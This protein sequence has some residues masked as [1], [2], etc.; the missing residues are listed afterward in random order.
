MSILRHAADASSV[1]MFLGA[2]IVINEAS[3]G[4]RISHPAPRLITVTE[5]QE[6]DVVRTM[7]NVE[8]RRYAPC[9]MADV[10]VRGDYRRATYEGFGP[11]VTY[12][13]RNDIAMTAPVV[14]EDTGNESWRV[15]FVMP[16]GMH[17]ST[18]P[19]PANQQVTLRDVPE[20]LAAALKFAGL[21][22]RRDVARK[23][24]DLLAA[25]RIEGLTPTS[26]VRVARFDPPWT[27]SF[28]R[29]N[30]LVVDVAV[31]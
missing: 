4:T 18:L 21:A 26:A 27:P 30:E 23:E 13:S 2:P 12:I 15:S 20:H 6:Y 11:L 17:L 19:R 28:L 29:H 22:T 5:Q 25:L 14:Q 8:L 1:R 16:S 3:A 7:G 10:I 24:H 9:V 31:G